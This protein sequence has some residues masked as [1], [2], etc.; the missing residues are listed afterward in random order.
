MKNKINIQ[1]PSG[2]NRAVTGWTRAIHNFLLLY[3]TYQYNESRLNSLTFLLA[4]TVHV[5][6]VI[7][8]SMP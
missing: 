2:G 6:E 7:S 4:L 5:P 3:T 8:Q 1:N